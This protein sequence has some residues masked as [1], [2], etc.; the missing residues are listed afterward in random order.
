[1]ISLS[2]TP[3][4]TKEQ[5]DLVTIFVFIS[6]H[7]NEEYYDKSDI[8]YSSYNNILPLQVFIPKNYCCS[9]SKINGITKK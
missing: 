2:I 1:M 3:I 7:V 9:P 4:D 6:F 8:N 5:I